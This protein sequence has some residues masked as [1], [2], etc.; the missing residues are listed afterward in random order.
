[1]G[2]PC[3]HITTVTPSGSSTNIEFTS[4]PAT[5]D[6]LLIIGTLKGANTGAW[7]PSA[8]GNQIIFGE[9][10][11]Y[12][13]STGDYNYEML[14]DEFSSTTF[15]GYKNNYSSTGDSA[16]IS[17]YPIPGSSGDAN[18]PAAYWL[19]VPGYAVTTNSPGRNWQLFA[20]CLSTNSNQHEYCQVSGGV[21][22]RSDAINKIKFSSGVGNFTASSKLSLYGITNS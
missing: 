12:W 16:H 13:N 8:S 14:Y 10:S 20:G 3:T 5:Y 1:M 18:N 17:A 21:I 7:T 11:T 9:G 22:D 15:L 6:D 4:I 2:N 19:Y